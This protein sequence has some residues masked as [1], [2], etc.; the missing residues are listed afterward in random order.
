MSG[1]YDP[2]N[3]PQRAGFFSRIQAAIQDAATGGDLGIVGMPIVHNYG[4]IGEFV[5]ITNENQFNEIFGDSDSD[6]RFAVLGAL[7]GDED[8]G[9]ANEVL[10][11]RLDLTAGTQAKADITLDDT[12]ATPA[13]TLTAKHEGTHGNTFAVT[14]E[15]DPANAAN[16]R[17]RVYKGSEL[18]ETF[19][20]PD[21]DIQALVDAVN[22]TS[23][24]SDLLDAALL[25]DG[26]ALAAVSSQALTGG[27][28]GTAASGDYDVAQ[29]AFESQQFNIFCIP[30]LTSSPIRA[31]FQT[32]IDSVNT[33]SKRVM[34]VEGGAAAESVATAIA[35]SA[36]TSDNENF[37]NV[38]GIDFIDP[39]GNTKSSAQMVGHIAG[40]IAAAGITKNLT[41]N[42]IAGFD[43]STNLSNDDLVTAILG[44]VLI[45]SRD[46]R[47]IKVERERTTYTDDTVDKPYTLFRSIRTVR[48]IHKVENDLTVITEDEWIGKVQNTPATRANYLGEVLEFLRGLEDQNAV[49]SGS[50][51]V[52]FDDTQD[53]TGD[54][55]HVILTFEVQGV[56]EV[57][58]AIGEIS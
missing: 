6:A 43:I 10:L 8:N 56:I 19:I 51:A 25:S 5:T 58:L 22:D 40:M 15:D 27:D 21:A 36:E 4:P 55:L 54:T 41:Y 47:G 35:R 31:S 53:N 17:L 46:D 24:G 9:G 16:D 28:N 34:M 44:G 12:G 57:V 30:N 29:T 49:V 18:Q 39:D 26:I 48:I 7:Q 32:W 13:I 33:S 2:N 20:Y 23:T 3:L 38:G 45:F 14:V 11:Y 52:R 42:R 1:L 50:S 37:V